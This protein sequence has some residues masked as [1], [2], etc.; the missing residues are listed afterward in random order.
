MTEDQFA[1]G[2]SIAEGCSYI[3]KRGIDEPIAII[4]R[5]GDKVIYKSGDVEIVLFVK[6]KWYSLLKWNILNLDGLKIG[7]MKI[8]HPLFKRTKI[9]IN[10]VGTIVINT[11]FF[12]LSFSGDN[13]GTRI[14]GM[15]IN[16]RMWVWEYEDEM[17]HIDLLS[18][19]I[20]HM[21]WW[22]GIS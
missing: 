4:T 14:Q 8:V 21:R 6:A 16:T 9:S 10:Q 1:Y 22:S 2:A 7:E 5:K 15:M 20:I 3:L 18:M 17:K 12:G 11:P 13:A 19:S